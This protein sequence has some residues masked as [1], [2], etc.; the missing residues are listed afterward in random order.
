MA[1]V[2]IKYKDN[3]IAEMDS[4]ATKTLTTG[5]TYCEDDIN[6]TYD[7]KGTSF[8]SLSTVDVVIGANTITLGGDAM[9]YLNELAGGYLCAA[10]LLDNPNTQNQL[11]LA[12]GA[13]DMPN[14]SSATYRAMKPGYRLRDGETQVCPLYRDYGFMLKEGT[15]YRLWIANVD[16]TNLAPY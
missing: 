15:R 7:D 11:I 13:M 3:V 14:M 2:T 4:S 16:V 1:D 12:P 8:L 5:G 9:I 6:V 10:A